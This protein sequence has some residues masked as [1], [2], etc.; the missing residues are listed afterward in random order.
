M[1]RSQKIQMGILAE[2]KWHVLYAMSHSFQVIYSSFLAECTHPF[3]Y[4]EINQ[5]NKLIFLLENT[6][7][8]EEDGYEG[9]SS[10]RHDDTC[11][12]IPNMHRSIN[13]IIHSVSSICLMLKDVYFKL[14]ALATWV[15]RQPI[16]SRLLLSDYRDER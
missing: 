10:H 12:I 7:R 2:R 15:I 11:G 9:T 16:R 6:T 4:T 8:R 13:I 5:S 1:V 14:S 3:S